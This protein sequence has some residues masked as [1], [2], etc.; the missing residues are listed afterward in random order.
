M[1]LVTVPTTIDIQPQCSSPAKGTPCALVEL[2][3]LSQAL[4][5]WL[6]LVNNAREAGMKI[7]GEFSPYEI[8]M[9]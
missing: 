4:T 7:A 9:Q 2:T 6:D 1:V 5:D 8:T 3:Q